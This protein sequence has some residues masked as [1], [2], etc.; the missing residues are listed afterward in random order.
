VIEER[1]LPKAEVTRAAMWACGF[2]RRRPSRRPVRVTNQTRALNPIR[3]RDQIAPGLAA[4]GRRVVC[5]GQYL[6]AALAVLD[7]SHFISVN[8]PSATDEIPK[9]N[10]AGDSRAEQSAGSGPV[11]GCLRILRQ[12]EKP[13]RRR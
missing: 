4:T 8:E 13:V 1:G 5:P 11:G 3:A 12:A 6:P 7:M 2:Q 9:S 10:H